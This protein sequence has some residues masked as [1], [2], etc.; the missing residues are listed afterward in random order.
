LPAIHGAAKKAAP[1][2]PDPQGAH[3]SDYVCGRIAEA[4]IAV[5]EN[6]SVPLDPAP[7]DVPST[8]VGG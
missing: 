1:H 5:M 8:E 3:L 7:L 4:V 6:R 2:E